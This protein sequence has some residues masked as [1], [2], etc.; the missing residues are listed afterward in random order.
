MTEPVSF[1]ILDYKKPAETRAC[2][3]SIRRHAK[4]DHKIIYLDNGS[5]ESYPHDLYRDG[6]ADV[7]ISKRRGMGGGVGQTDLFRWCDTR[8]AFFVQ[9]D[10]TL[11]HD[12]EPKHIDRFID[13][14]S[15]GARVVDC[16]GDQSQQG[17]WTDR[18]HFIDVQ[19]FNSLAPFPNGGPGELHHLRWNEN[20]LQE[21]F[22][23]LDNPIIHVKPVLFE[24]NGVWT[25]RE[26][27][28]GGIVKM[29][30]DTKAVTWVKSPKERYIFPE[31]TDAEWA[32][33]IGGA[34]V[35]GTVPNVYIQRN[36]SFNHWGTS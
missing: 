14:L 25:V 7:I 1:L 8:Y 27:P 19:W 36:Q 12:I 29:R 23:K 4:I 33:A 22:D 6:L 10:Q 20:Y 21:V 35:A 15:N 31:H 30:T 9:S 32:A 28:C 18:A 34:W 24:D 2:L 16:N 17:R 3:E 5:N 13:A 11:V 26:L